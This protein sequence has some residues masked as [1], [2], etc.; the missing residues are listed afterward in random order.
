MK[1]AE[2]R[3]SRDRD[4]DLNLESGHTAY[5]H[6]SFIDL[7]YIPNFI[8]IKATFYGR[9]DGRTDRHL[10]PTLLGR[11]GG[12]STQ[13]SRPNNALLSCINYSYCSFILPTTALK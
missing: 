4:L 7:Y 1:M 10:R 11:L 8:E 3:V 9:T 5:R 12:R 6:A 2:F 13:R